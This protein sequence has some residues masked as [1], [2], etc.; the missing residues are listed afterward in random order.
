MPYTVRQ[1]TPAHRG[2]VVGAYAVGALVLLAVPYIV[3][4]GDKWFGNS[5]GQ[6]I[7]WQRTLAFAVAI[8]GLNLLIGFSGQISIGHSAFVGLGAY[9]AVLMTNN[10]VSFYLALPLVMALCFAVGCVI[11]LPALRIKGLYL[12]VVTFALAIVFPTL[13]EKY[14]SVTGGSNGLKGKSSLV[15]KAPFDKLFDPKDRIEPLRYRYY[16]LLVVAVIMFVTARN[17]V[18]SRAGR[19][20]VA[21][22][23][24]P[25]AATINGVPTPIYKV[26]A[27]G[28]SAAYC[29][30]AG[31]MLM[32]RD[33]SPFASEGSFAV[34]L[35]ITLIIGL[36]M[37]GVAS[38]GGAIPG[39]LIVVIVKYLLEQLTNKK[40]LLGIKMNWLQTRPG[41]GGVV[42]IA[43]G[44]LLLG[45][46]FILPGGVM[47]GLRRLRMRFVRIVPHPRW[48]RESVG[49]PSAAE[50]T[51]REGD[52]ALANPVA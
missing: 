7:N 29:G 44:V 17:M 48:L 14:E 36:V 23:D 52:A 13:V 25:T 50:R 10:H 19:G 9:G 37:G 32:A 45:F 49:D 41:K 22:R 5:T 12:V 51:A 33:A 46:V 27:F 1:G 24:N 3:L 6:L 26:L 8:L 28:I 35:S 42:S 15:P 38:I 39:A 18:R 21:L 47:D 34:D 40:E 20:L 11:G 30:A 4:P 2:L 43:F 16:V 31:W